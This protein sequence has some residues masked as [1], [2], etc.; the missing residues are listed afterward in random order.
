MN[1]QY[2]SLSN[3]NITGVQQF[4]LELEKLGQID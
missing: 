3:M 4:E 2:K 1:R